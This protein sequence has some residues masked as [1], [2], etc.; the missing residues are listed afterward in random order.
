MSLSP[1]VVR[2]YSADRT[3]LSHKFDCMAPVGFQKFSINMLNLKDYRYTVDFFA[4][5]IQISTDL[6]LTTVVQ[7][8]S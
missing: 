4:Q 7:T 6:I 3:S 5:E 1:L 8:V 2:R